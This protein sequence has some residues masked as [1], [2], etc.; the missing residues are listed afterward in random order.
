MNKK[1]KSKK[2]KKVKLK[3]NFKKQKTPKRKQTIKSLK[4]TIIPIVETI[5]PINQTIV[6]TEQSIIPIEQPIII[7][8][9]DVQNIDDI[10]DK[11][12]KNIKIDLE[13]IKDKKTYSKY[14]QMISNMKTNLQQ[15]IQMKS[16]N[17][18]QNSIY[19]TLFTLIIF[20]L[21]V[22]CFWPYI[23]NKDEII[24][25]FIE[26]KTTI[27]KLLPT[28]ININDFFRN[29]SANIGY[30]IGSGITNIFVLS[31]YIIGNILWYG[32]IILSYSFSSTLTG[33]GTFIKS[34][35]VVNNLGTIF[36]LLTSILIMLAII[37]SL[38]PRTGL[39][40]K[41]SQKITYGITYTGETLSR[42]GK[43][44]ANTF[45]RNIIGPG[46]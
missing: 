39:I 4:Q 31:Y 43:I 17:S 9:K 12:N 15:N 18:E 40:P 14:L 36:I 30:L 27:T 23:S 10:T 2:S 38:S 32:G 37:N 44:F 1:K 28:Q 25:Q 3:L 35:L 22:I 16:D 33:M 8:P 41:I 29:I 19:K 11:I 21:V 46:T 45:Y 42:F 6:P 26:L 13:K 20:L 24:S 7:K 34:F 5:K